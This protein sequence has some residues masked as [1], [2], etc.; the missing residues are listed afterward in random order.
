MYTL[1]IFN[2]K[3][4]QF[5]NVYETKYYFFAWLYAKWYYKTRICG[6]VWQN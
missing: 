4:N 1:Q 2:D 5:V 6:L 3:L